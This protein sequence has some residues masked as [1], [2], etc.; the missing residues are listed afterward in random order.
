MSVMLQE[1]YAISLLSLR[2]VL[3]RNRAIYYD[4]CS[5]KRHVSLYFFY[6]RGAFFWPPDREWERSI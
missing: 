6:D 4:S 2:S 5:G 1:D 3:Y